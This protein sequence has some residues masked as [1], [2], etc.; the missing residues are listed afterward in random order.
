M[1]TVILEGP[2]GAGKTTLAQELAK[3][4]YQLKYRHLGPPLFPNQPRLQ[5]YLRELR[6]HPHSVVFDRLHLGERVYGP[7]VREHD[8]LGDV[9]QR[10]LERVLLGRGAVCV[11][12]LPPIETVVE[13]WAR[14]AGTEY[15][16]SRE[17]IIAVYHRYCRIKTDVPTILFDY[18]RHSIRDTIEKIW[19]EINTWKNYGPGIGAWRPYT[20]TLLVGDQVNPKATIDG[21]PFVAESGS[22]VYITEQL[23]AA[24]VPENKL[25]WVNA[26][27][28]DGSET[29]GDFIFDLNPRRVVALGGNAAKWCSRHGFPHQKVSHPAFWK[30]FH[31]N[32]PYQEL[33]DALAGN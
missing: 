22:S 7:I 12:C 16:R 26:K 1:F 3:S 30:R 28:L 15:V 33:I 23:Q 4:K 10:M 24:G 6:E 25:Y 9:G 2:D 14:R 31:A 5:E 19:W 27:G 21:Y 8:G 17:Q 11:M 13:N 29:S 32:E 18:T 20:S